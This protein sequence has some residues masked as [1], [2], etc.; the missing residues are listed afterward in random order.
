MIGPKRLEEVVEEASKAFWAEVAKQLPEFNAE[1]LDH[2]TVITLQWQMKT[3]VER[4]IQKDIEAIEASKE[5]TK[6]RVKR[7]EYG[8]VLERNNNGHG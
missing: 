2:G 4:W 1:S 3:S 6:P 8:R 5:K 7:D